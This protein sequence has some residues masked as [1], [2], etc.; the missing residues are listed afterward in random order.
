[1]VLSHQNIV[2]PTSPD[3]EIFYYFITYNLCKLPTAMNHM[4]QYTMFYT[5]TSSLMH[6]PDI[7]N[8]PNGCTDN[9]E[10]IMKT[11]TN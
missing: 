5:M 1:M 3:R 8:V 6:A 10:T 7:P 2:K 9:I 11:M 4:F